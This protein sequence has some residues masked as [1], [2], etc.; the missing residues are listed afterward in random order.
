[1]YYK[2]CN[3]H[4]LSTYW[5]IY[6]QFYGLGKPNMYYKCRNFH[7]FKYILGNF[8]CFSLT[9]GKCEGIHL[10]RHISLYLQSSVLKNVYQKGLVT[11]AQYVPCCQ[12]GY[13][14]L[15]VSG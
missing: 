11:K 7:V 8:K 6:G 13:S 2:Y 14:A 10:K 1:M 5:A 12:F 4:F 9:R 15:R 3:L